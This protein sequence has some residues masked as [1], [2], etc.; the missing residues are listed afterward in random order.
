MEVNKNIKV[1]LSFSSILVQ[2]KM[3]KHTQH[4]LV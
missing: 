4:A 1:N 3:V 2:N